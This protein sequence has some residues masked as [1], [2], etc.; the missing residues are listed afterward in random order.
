MTEF[1]IDT[2]NHQSA[3]GIDIGRIRAE[4]YGFLT[5]KLIQGDGYVDPFFAGVYAQ[6]R[7]AFPGRFGAYVYCELDVAPNVEADAFERAAAA[8][9]GGPGAFPVQIDYEDT[10]PGVRGRASGADLTARV[11]EYVARGWSL[12]PIYLPRWYWD[13]YMGSPDLS[14]LPAGLWNSNY[15]G[16]SGAALNLYPGDGHAGW[17]PFGGLNVDILQFSEQGSTAGEY[18]IDLN[19]FRGT[20]AELDHLF[21]G[22]T[23]MADDV[24]Q[25][26]LEQE[27]GEGATVATTPGWPARRYHLPPDK[28]P[29]FSQTDFLREVDAKT[30]SE[31]PAHGDEP[32]PRPKPLDTPDDLFG[33]VLSL[34]A[35]EEQTQLMLLEIGRALRD[36]DYDAGPGELERALISI[37]GDRA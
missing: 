34:R 28:Q 9:G 27:K 3:D 23:S 7:T 4:G 6:A 13:G 31:L 33:H 19:A 21:A 29:R 16:G 26:I 25:A 20:P 2:S 22:G 35:Q 30:N 5:H 1:G 32:N 24:A 37:R 17:E 15:V 36:P 8:A 12:L 18:P 10:R 14:H 11:N